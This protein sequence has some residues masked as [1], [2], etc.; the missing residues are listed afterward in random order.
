MPDEFVLLRLVD[1]RQ[2]I[3]LSLKAF[4]TGARQ[5][6]ELARSLLRSTSYWVYD[7][8][9]RSFAPSKFVGF[10]AMTFSRYGLA[11]RGHCEG[12]RFNGHDT[13]MAVEKC[14]GNYS[15]NPGLSAELVE[16]GEILL[17]PAVLDGVDRGKWR[18]VSL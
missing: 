8:H 2:D 4:N 7:C 9:S 11:R 10:K 18:F 3:Q 5:N 15:Q 12:S 17:G 14:L 6:H 16:W 1:D 13:R